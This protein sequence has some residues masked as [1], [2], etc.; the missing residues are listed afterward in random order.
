M[1]AASPPP[2]AASPPLPSASP[3]PLVSLSGPPA[4][5]C[6][7]ASLTA[8]LEP[9]QGSSAGAWHA[10]RLTAATCGITTTPLGVATASGEPPCS[11]ASKCTPVSLSHPALGQR[12]KPGRHSP[13][14]AVQALSPPPPAAS[15]PPPVSPPPPPPPQFSPADTSAAKPAHTKRMQH[16]AHAECNADAPA[17][18]FQAGPLFRVRQP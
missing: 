13:A 18:R 1:Q 9:P 14:A 12:S 8:L 11:S 3:P 4:M 10:G 15:P 6:T 7:A 16:R 2:P 5:F 17:W